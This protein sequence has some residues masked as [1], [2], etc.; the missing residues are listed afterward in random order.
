MR[1]A[2]GGE[3][4]QDHTLSFTDR[5]T[6]ESYVCDRAAEKQTSQASKRWSSSTPRATNAG[7]VCNCFH[8]CGYRAR[9]NHAFPKR[10]TRVREKATKPES[11]SA[12][13]L[14][15]RRFATRRRNLGPG[16]QLLIQRVRCCQRYLGGKRSEMLSHHRIRLR[17]QDSQLKTYRLCVILDEVDRLFAIKL[18]NPFS[19]VGKHLLTPRSQCKR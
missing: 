15:E 13:D 14:S 18:R 9:A 6:V 7:R 4:A 3:Q 2:I 19:G 11:R 17:G 10:L 5:Q 12:P 1:V 16:F 8:S